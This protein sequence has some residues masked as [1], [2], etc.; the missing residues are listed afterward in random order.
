MK[1]AFRLAILG[2]GICLVSNLNAMD[3]MDPFEQL[4]QEGPIAALSLE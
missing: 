2:L 4:C 3:N 1:K